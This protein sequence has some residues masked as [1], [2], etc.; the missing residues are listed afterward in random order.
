MKDHWIWLFVGGRVALVVVAAFVGAAIDRDLL[1]QQAAA[2]V[3]R[4]LELLFRLFGL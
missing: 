4:V 1:D 3:Q 2:A